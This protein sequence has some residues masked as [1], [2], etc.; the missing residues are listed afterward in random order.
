MIERFCGNSKSIT[1]F[2]K[3]SS[4]M[5]K[6]VLITHC[7]LYLFM[8]IF[9]IHCIE[10]YMKI[11]QQ[12]FTNILKSRCSKKFRKFHQKKAGLEFLFKKDEGPQSCNLIKKRL[13]HRCFP[14][15]FAKFIRTPFSTVHLGWLLF[16]I[17]NSNNLFKDF[18]AV[19]LVKQILITC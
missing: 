7:Q 16:K 10:T 8:K 19:F 17:S 14:V 6:R 15:K 5:F 1:V 2:E 12:S 9:F 13:Q 3:N 18:L 11:Q 4:Y